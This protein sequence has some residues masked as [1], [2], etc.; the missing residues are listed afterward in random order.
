MSPEIERLPNLIQHAASALASATTAAEVLDVIDLAD[1][2]YTA[3]KTALRLT[4]AKRAHDEV[5]A[6]ARKVMGD[7]LIIEARA[8]CRL[9]EECDAAQERGEVKSAGQPRKRIIPNENNSSAVTDLGLTSK[10]IHEARNVR[11][12]EEREPGIVSKI[13]GEKLNAGEAPT[14]ADVKRAVRKNESKGDARPQPRP[15]DPEQP[16][17]TKGEQSKL[18]AYKRKLDRDFDKTE[19]RC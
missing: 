10:L 9:A 6:A 16:A 3:A 18:D 4:A 17:L 1:V 7:A 13:V 8:Q 11:D 15:V 5:V 2:A 19:N 14:R 12:A